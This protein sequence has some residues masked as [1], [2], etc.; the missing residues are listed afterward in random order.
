MLFRTVIAKGMNNF[1][2]MFFRARGVLYHLPDASGDYKM[3][4]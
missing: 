2:K 4:L 3:M 1:L